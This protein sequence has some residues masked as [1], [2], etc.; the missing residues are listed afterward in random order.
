M[1]EDQWF[2]DQRKKENLLN[3]LSQDSDVY[4]I[5]PMSRFIGMLRVEKNTLV[6]PEKWDDPFEN[7]LFSS[8]A[9]NQ[10]GQAVTLDN[11]RNSYFGQCW[12]FNIESFLFLSPIKGEVKRK[13]TSPDEKT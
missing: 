9:K 1:K 2:T 3:G 8:K 5:F 6:K 10:H 7:F 4:R 11:I 12:S 13:N